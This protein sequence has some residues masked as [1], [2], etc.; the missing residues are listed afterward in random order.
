MVY[1]IGDVISRISAFLLLPIYTRYFTPE[2]FGVL[3]IFY[4]AAAVISI[5]LGKEISHAML[6][7]Y[8]EYPLQEDKNSLVS[9]SFILYAL[10]ASLLLGI[11]S[12]FSLQFS[13]YIFDTYDYSKH[14]LYLFSWL[15]FSLVNEIGYSYLRAREKAIT[16][17]SV[18]FLELIIKLTACIYL[19]VYSD[20]GVLGV[21]IGNLLGVITSFLILGGYVFSGC[22]FRVEPSKLSD[23]IRYMLPLMVVGLTGTIIGQADRY[24][25][26]MYT[27]LALVGL[28]GLG[29][30]FS[31]I[32]AF[33]VI[34]PFTK[35]YGPFRFS[36]MD[37]DNA[38]DIYARVTTY[39]C[40]ILLWMSLGMIALAREVI[41]IMAMESYWSAYDVIPILLIS[42]LGQGLYYMFQIGVYIK[43][44]TKVLS[45][46]FIVASIF[47]ILCLWLLVPRYQIVG[48]AIAVAATH[49]IIAIGGLVL[50][51][52]VYPIE[53]EWNRL[54]K[55]LV[56]YGFL[57]VPGCMS[58]HTDPYWSALIK[59]PLFILYPMILL[60]IKFF[61]GNEIEAIKK[62]GKNKLGRF[63]PV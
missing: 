45:Y 33:L 8:Y 44:N 21:L 53:Y 39:F 23:A 4:M 47:N 35:G 7:F 55:S 24:F 10:T 60:R 2:Q 48:A 5:F 18:S 28:Y 11:C 37:Q 29:M 42:V 12:L 27:S 56:V 54:L 13:F 15:F 43:K 52:K 9:S 31:T 26:N 19:I 38:K 58:F 34:Q 50:S 32:I 1:G 14:F 63:S 36:I 49:I 17:V 3:E 59:L 46:L 6:R 40:F 62:F 22:G 30:R 20:Y 16:F 25:L 41:Q 51:N 61:T 57:L